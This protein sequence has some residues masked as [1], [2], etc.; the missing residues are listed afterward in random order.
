MLHYSTVKHMKSRSPVSEIAMV[1][2]CEHGGNRVPAAYR[3]LFRNCRELLNSHRGFDPGALAMAQS[4]S[5]NFSAPMLTST[6]TR[7]LVDLNRSIGH[8]NLHMDRI[9]SLPDMVRQQ[10]VDCYYQPYRSAGERLVEQQIAR[11][12]R[13]IH[14]SCHSFTNELNG[15]VRDTDIGL[16]YD[17][18]R[19]AEKYL[20]GKW[21]SA[22]K[23]S[24]T[25]LKVRRN[26]PYVGSSDG[27]TSTLRR[28]FPD[29]SYLGIEL[30]INQRNILP[31][32]KKLS[33]LR[34]SII[35]SLSI[36][37]REAEPDAEMAR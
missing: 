23:Q 34:V 24:A 21:K 37:L 20:C 5:R 16:L 11:H 4:L 6:V 15:H 25:E 10:I 27:F 33:T 35:S 8:P 31:P 12:G 26:F 7:L 30:E 13:V 17:S 3:H 18:T 32:S 22:L 2:T 29:E 19:Q 14:I 36:A 28:K 1:I 9:R